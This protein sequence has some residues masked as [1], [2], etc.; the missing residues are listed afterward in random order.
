MDYMIAPCVDLAVADRAPSADELTFYDEQHMVTYLR[1]LVADVLGS[2]W[3]E[4][5][6]VALHRDPV[7]EPEQSLRCW[8]SHLARG[9]WMMTRGYRM[10]LNHGAGQSDA[11]IST[12]H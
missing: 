8:E 7:A 11:S 3:Q 2:A 10:M 12:F 9:H 1:L 4:V 6:R 5:A